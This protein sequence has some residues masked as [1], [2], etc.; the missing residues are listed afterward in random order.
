MS[1][2]RRST[3]S[4]AGT[5]GLIVVALAALAGCSNDEAEPATQ[6]E[7]TIVEFTDAQPG[8]LIALRAADT[9]PTVVEW[10]D[11]R[12]GTIRSIDIDDPEA[13]VVL[14]SI[15][16][17]TD[18]EQRGL[19]GHTTID[20]I[21][22]AA[23]TTPETNHLVVGSLTDAEPAVVDRI[24][25]DAGGTAGG[26]VGGHLE[27][28]AD[29]MLVLGIG[30]LTDWAKD[31]GSGAM[32]QLDPLGPTDQEP[33]VLSD[34]YINPFAFTVRGD[35][36]W[37]ADNAV[38][39]DTERT[40]FV[41]LAA[42]STRVDR[43]DLDPTGEGPR[44]PSAMVALADDTIGVCGFLDAELRPWS[45][46]TPG[47]GAPLGPCLTGATALADGTIVTATADAL[48]AIAP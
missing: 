26:A 20:G 10:I 42:G 27:A 23:W 4:P 43:G 13:I 44:A 18:G 3:A 46:D 37:V 30:Q 12:A 32:L 47:Y 9:D 28:T 11:R 6:S 5:A 34:G 39:D 33:V 2:L 41:D 7:R 25:W 48:V 35:R 29:G 36:L 40:G 21:R 19:L 38:G 16:V 45:P 1:S 14:A 24:V 8:D 22:Y 31:H 15:D 17:G